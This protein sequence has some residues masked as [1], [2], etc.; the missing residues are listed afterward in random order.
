MA[1]PPSDATS[2]AP[3]PGPMTPHPV[4][5]QTAPP[6]QPPPSG[7]EPMVPWAAP[8]EPAGPAPGVRFAPHGER[9]VAYI[10]DSLIVFGLVLVVS[11]I[12]LAMLAVTGGIGSG[13]QPR[14]P[15]V[16]T[17][18]LIMWL[19]AILFISLGYFPFFWQG[20]GQTP[21]MRVFG[22][23]VVRDR[24]GQPFGW[25]TAM[26]RLLGLYVASSVFYLGLIWI[27]FDK[28]RRGWQDLIAGTIVVKR[29]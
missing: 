5:P 27:F 4:Q 20:R 21:G 28:R 10:L 9:L 11:L 29:N 3:E 23:Y 24:D 2:P 26:L 16:A 12:L 19:I 15:A 8:A 6:Q 17:F 14:N 25:G 7:T 18:A 13:G 22:L 1:E